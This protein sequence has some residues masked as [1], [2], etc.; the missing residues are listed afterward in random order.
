MVCT[1][2][3]ADALVCDASAAGQLDG[4]HTRKR[5]HALICDA[6]AMGQVDNRVRPRKRPTPSPVMR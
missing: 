4:A 6:V 3:S 2:E 1:P 5:L